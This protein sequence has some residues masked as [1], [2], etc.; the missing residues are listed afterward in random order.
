MYY[1]TILWQEK[2]TLCI[3][4]HNHD[5]KRYTW[6]ITH[7]WV[8]YKDTAYLNIDYTLSKSS[9]KVYESRLLVY[10]NFIQI[11]RKEIH[12]NYIAQIYN[13]LDLQESALENL[14][15][16]TFSF[17][18]NKV[19]VAASKPKAKRNKTGFILYASNLPFP[20]RREKIKLL[21]SVS[22]TKSV[23][24]FCN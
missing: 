22:F 14:V 11:Q 3:I 17:L 9:S 24:K 21:Q 5:K 23:L 19:F 1:N 18:F 6:N 10:A 16:N 2:V 20:N 4:T 7:K 12:V 15:Q 13:D 8:T